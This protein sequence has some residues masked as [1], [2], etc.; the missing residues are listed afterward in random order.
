MIHVTTANALYQNHCG[1]ACQA[2][3]GFGE[4]LYHQFMSW[5]E[6]NIYWRLHITLGVNC[7]YLFLAHNS[8]RHTISSSLYIH[9]MC[10]LQCDS[11]SDYCLQINSPLTTSNDMVSLSFPPLPGAIL[12]SHIEQPQNPAILVL[13]SLQNPSSQLST[14]SP[15][16]HTSAP[17]KHSKSHMRPTNTTTPRWATSW[18]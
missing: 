9:C 15:A 11:Q 8:F 10:L 12:V 2:S 17:P 16:Q 5:P 4:L 6:T 14:D 3:S 7:N 18:I 1:N 13:K